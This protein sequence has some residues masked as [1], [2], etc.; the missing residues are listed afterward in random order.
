MANRAVVQQCGSV[1]ILL[2][3]AESKEDGGIKWRS[4][5]FNTFAKDKYSSAR[6]GRWRDPRDL[7]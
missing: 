7:A 4:D 6:V 2:T 3:I 1:W 5:H